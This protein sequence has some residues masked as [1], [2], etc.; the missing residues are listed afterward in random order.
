[1]VQC[2]ARWPQSYWLELIDTDSVGLEKCIFN[3]GWMVTERLLTQHSEKEF[4]TI[5]DF[6]VKLH[7]VFK[8]CCLLYVGKSPMNLINSKQV[9]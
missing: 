6:K 3:Q 4:R 7:T 9:M 1:M 2:S 8:P 5:K